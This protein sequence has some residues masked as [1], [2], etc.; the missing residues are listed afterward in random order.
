MG[1]L[2]EGVARRRVPV[3]GVVGRL[4][5]GVARRRVPAAG[6]QEGVV[7]GV[8]SQH[9]LQRGDVIPPREGGRPK[10]TPSRQPPCTSPIRGSKTALRGAGNVPS[11]GASPRWELDTMRW[12]PQRVPKRSPGASFGVVP[13]GVARGRVPVE[14]VLGM[15]Q[16]GVARLRVPVEGVLGRLQGGVARLRVPA[17]GIQEGVVWGVPSQHTLQRGDVTPL[18]RGGSLFDTLLISTMYEP[19]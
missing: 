16:E 19:D 4:Q 7:W 2:Q 14:S 11:I 3:E 15:L 13:E 10:M 1:R 12:W 5:E 9:T 17:A 8:P 18:V 6:V